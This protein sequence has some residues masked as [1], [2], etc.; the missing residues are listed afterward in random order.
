MSKYVTKRDGSKELFDV[1]KSLKNLKGAFRGCDEELKVFNNILHS[2]LPNLIKTSELQ[3]MYISIAKNNIDPM[4]DFSLI[5]GRLLMHELYRIVEGQGFKFNEFAEHTTHYIDK[6]IYTD[7]ISSI[8]TFDE[9]LELSEFMTEDSDYNLGHSQVS[10]IQSKYLRK[11]NGQIFEYNTHVDMLNAILLVGVNDLD[12][13][14]HWYSLFRDNIVS[15]ATT[16]HTGLRF[17]D[18]SSSCYIGEMDDNLANISYSWSQIAKISKHGGGIGWYLG[19]LRPEGTVSNGVYRANHINVWTK[20]LNDII[21]AVNQKG[22]SKGALTLALPIWHMDIELF[23]ETKLE[24]GSDLRMKSFDIFPQIVLDDYFVKKAMNNESYNLVNHYEWEKYS[25]I[26]LNDLVGDEL[27]EEQLKIDEEIKMGN[28]DYFKT[29]NA[30]ELWKSILRSWIAIGGEYITHKDNLNISNYLAPNLIT[31]CANLCVESFSITKPTTSWIVSRDNDLDEVT[32]ETNGLIHVCDL[33]SIN[34]ANMFNIEDGYPTTFN[35]ELF[36]DAVSCAVEMLDNN[37][38]NSESPVLEGRKSSDLLRNIGIGLIGVGDYMACKLEYYDT[39]SGVKT[40]ESI[41]ERLAWYAYNKSIKLAESRGSYNLFDKADYSK[42]F[43]K[44]PQELTTHS[45]NHFN[46]SDLVDRINTN[47]I[48]N[49]YIL[50]QA[51]NTRTALK[52]GVVPS[53]LPPYSNDNN[54]LLSDQVLRVLPKY[55]KTHYKFY[56]TKFQYRASDM[57]KVTCKAQKFLDTGISFEV[58]LDPT[59]EGISNFSDVVLTAFHNKELKALYYSAT[60]VDA[61]KNVKQIKQKTT[62]VSCEN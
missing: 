36:E 40:I 30:K 57:V 17:G 18:N 11:L 25:G 23:M 61:M 56:K 50:A 54:Q 33:I 8:V 12:K 49:F 10:V 39:P 55:I 6:G 43:G 34:V 48:R 59:V 41:Y 5:A 44:C 37:K 14:K 62:C 3:N 26:N 42:I 53:Y 28:F 13:I 4:N 20:I 38:D 31:Q 29:I 7:K 32:L 35:E 58:N 2:D 47:G 19:R 27:F 52:Q 51:P 21:V 16:L 22:I 15:L 24:S 60:L 1:E 45:I 46:W 9:L